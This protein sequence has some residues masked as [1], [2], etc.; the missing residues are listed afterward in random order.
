MQEWLRSRG[1]EAAT[2]ASP[3]DFAAYIRKDLAKWSKVVK[4]VGIHPE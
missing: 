4:G 2:S 3:E 1:A